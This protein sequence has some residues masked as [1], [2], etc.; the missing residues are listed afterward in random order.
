MTGLSPWDWA[1][2]V[3]YL[4]LA[5]AAGVLLARR[6]GS[7][8]E[9]YFVAERGLP[10]WWLGTSMVATTFAADTPLVVTGLVAEYGIAGNWFWWSWAIS[11]VSLAVVFAAMWRRARVLT[12]A[13]LVELRYGGLPATVLRG[14][15]AVFFAIVINGIVLG[16][17]VRAMVKITA[18]FTQWGAWIG[19]DRLA[20]FEAMWPAALTIG[21]PG[22]TLTVLVLFGLIALYSSLG[23]IRGVILTDLFQFLLAIGASIAFAWFAVAHVGGL[24][25]LVSGLEQHYDASQVLAFVPSSNAAW[26]PV[27]VFLIYIAVQ[28]WAQYFSDG[29]GYLAQRLFTAKN[30]AHAEGGAL[31]FAVANYALR[32]WPWVIIA[33]V[34]LVVYPL[35]MEGAGAGAAVVAADREM[36]YP[37]LMRELL[38][39]G[40][41]GLMVASLLAAFMSTVDT[42]INWG[43]SYLVNDLY[44]RFLRPAASQ[45][46]LVAVSRL[47][48]FLLAAL[49]VLVAAH[50]SSI[51][52][53]WRFFIALGAGLG[54]PSMMRWLWWRVNAWTEI[55]GMSVAVVMALV[56]YPLFPDAR[57]EYLLLVIIGVSMTAAI[58]ATFLT[59]PVP[60]ERLAEFAERVHP[61]GWWGTVPGAAPASATR[62]IAL[63][64]VAGNIGVFGLTFGVGHLLLGSRPLGAAMI[65]GGLAAIGLTMR[66]SGRARRVTGLTATGPLS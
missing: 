14:F 51:E 45:R 43:T 52:S 26:L 47:G 37:M 34:A 35:G 39:T 41:L 25:G 60:P 21:G 1:I 48:V 11:H 4:A 7:S 33:L 65:L 22:D 58:A 66:T 13:E 28:W 64:W 36:A 61:P 15:K 24:G 42:H 6:A 46:E 5:L 63:A 29:S 2:V 38:P 59:A 31:W 16:W 40:L 53:A 62:W 18:P 10:W 20:G 57:D 23:G 56:L 44:R 3:S 9:S 12:D 30:D 54:L 49:A 32:T 50:I 17:V 27:Q 55:V 8:L 19:A